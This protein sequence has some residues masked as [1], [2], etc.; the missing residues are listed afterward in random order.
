LEAQ[1]GS[2][3]ELAGPDAPVDRATLDAT[4]ATEV[5]IRVFVGDDGVLRRLSYEIDLGPVL[6]AAGAPA[7]GMAVETT[8]DVFDVGAADIVV[9]LPSRD[10]AVDLTDWIVAMVGQP[11]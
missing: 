3:D 5:P 8:L 2:V 4:L 7:D 1:G 11:G 9:E 6:A 10:D